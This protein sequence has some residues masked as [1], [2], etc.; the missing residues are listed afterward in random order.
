MKK[1]RLL[2]SLAVLVLA[3]HAAGKTIPNHAAAD[4]VLGQPDFVSTI[5]INTS[6]SN[7][8]ASTSVVVDPMTRKVFVG[9]QDGDRVLRYASADALA[10]GASAE[11]VFGQARFSTESANVPTV[12]LG[13]NDPN[14][15]FFDR[16]GRLWV[17]DSSNNRVLM[18]EAASFRDTQ[19]YPDLVLGQATFL[20]NATGTTDTTMN[21]PNGLW[22]DASDRLWVADSNNSRILRF[23]A[24][25][26]KY[27]G[28]SADGLLG[29]TLFTTNTTGS[30]ALRLAFPRSVAVSPTGA[31][32]VAD[33]GNHRVVRY[34][35]AA[36]KPLG[37]AADAVL[38]QAG[39]GTSATGITATTMD[40]PQ[41]VTCT[42]DDA[43]W[44]TESVNHRITRF[45]AASTQPNGA[46][47]TGVI[48][49]PNF[50][51]NTIGLSARDLN[52][53]SYACF[54]D[55]PGALW[56]PDSLNN[57]VL[58]FP[59]DI[60]APLLTLTTAVPK[61][62]TGKKLSL[63]GTASDAYGIARVQFKVN[64]GPLQ[65]ATGTTTW[66]VKAPLKLGKNTIT[67]IAT[68]SVGNLS[69]KKI[70]KIIR[71]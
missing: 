50:T 8:S 69:V 39:F 55:A 32:F 6:A 40:S 19:P 2:P 60:T 36:A 4:L 31:L 61:T 33:G 34:D 63:N 57:R 43:L 54:A 68:D 24:V 15:L 49:Q 64:A 21:Y 65:T 56:V 23:D 42:P 3:S 10:N 52:T 48:G 12:E 20:T 53:P 17:A 27:P 13:M 59:A 5:V 7:L 67:L 38:G 14:A 70:L 30:T 25:S 41:G 47:A 1:P 51:T 11:A 9:D 58:R 62:T 18:F 71:K 35:N 37:G 45:D 28:A 26:L 46:A 44:V 66:Q 29:Q 22:L 16:K